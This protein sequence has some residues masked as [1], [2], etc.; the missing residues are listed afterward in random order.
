MR[1]PLVGCT[2]VGSICLCIF[3]LT[4]M[5]KWNLAE[6]GNRSPGKVQRTRLKQWMGA[7]ITPA[8]PAAMC[9]PHHRNVVAQVL[10]SAPWW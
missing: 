7:I 4:L 10:P 9:I 8:C 5:A 6:P 1:L 3:V 2:T